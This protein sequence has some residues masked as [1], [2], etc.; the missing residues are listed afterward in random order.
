M[1]E[2]YRKRLHA[3]YA[4][5]DMELESAVLAATDRNDAVIVATRLC[6]RFLYYLL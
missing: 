4:S 3:V 1:T 5:Q 2:G 6:L